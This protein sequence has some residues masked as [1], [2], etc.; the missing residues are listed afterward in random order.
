MAAKNATARVAFEFKSLH[1]CEKRSKPCCYSYIG[2]FKFEPW[3]LSLRLQDI[4]MG[5]QWRYRWTAFISL[6]LGF[7]MCWMCFNWCSLMCMDVTLALQRTTQDCRKQN[8]IAVKVGL[9]LGSP[10][11]HPLGHVASYK[12]ISP[13]PNKKPSRNLAYMYSETH[14]IR[15]PTGHAIVSILTRYPF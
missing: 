5:G 13:K 3:L 7:F 4:P 6:S 2:M 15:T 1:V 9:E 10:T 12:N 14:L 11:F 8:Q